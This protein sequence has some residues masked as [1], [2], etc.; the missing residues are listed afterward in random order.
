MRLSTILVVCFLLVLLPVSAERVFV[1][2][3]V[4]QE[5]VNDQFYLELGN[6]LM[7]QGRDDL[8]IKAYQKGLE[9]DKNPALYQGI[10]YYYYKHAELEKATQNFFIA[11]TM[12]NSFEAP[13]RALA[14]IYYQKGNHLSAIKYLK[15]LIA[16]NNYNPNYWYD[17]GINIVD[18]YRVSGQG[19]LQ[20]AITAFENAEKLSPGFSYAKRNADWLKKNT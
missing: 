8:A 20:L 4:P 12:D 5:Q 7:E 9:Y 1:Q 16:L 2:S 15:E 13:R 17:L 19:D 3:N 14:I 18:E 6:R 10:G 11:A